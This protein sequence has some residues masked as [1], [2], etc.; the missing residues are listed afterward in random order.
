MRPL[1]LDCSRKKKK[2]SE[3]TANEQYFV[4]FRKYHSFYPK[5][6]LPKELASPNVLS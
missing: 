4:H 6:F 1:L 2:K 3:K 5:E